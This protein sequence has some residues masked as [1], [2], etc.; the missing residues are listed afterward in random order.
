MQVQEDHHLCCVRVC[1]V[2]VSFQVCGRPGVWPV[3]IV[4]NIQEQEEVSLSCR[5]HASS[6]EWW[7]GSAYC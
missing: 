7:T 1:V 6:V 2:V 4:G 3:K 5:V